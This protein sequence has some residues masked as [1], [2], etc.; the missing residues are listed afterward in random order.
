M[1]ALFISKF[2]YGFR[3]TRAAWDLGVVGMKPQGSRLIVAS[4]ELAGMKVECNVRYGTSFCLWEKQPADRSHWTVL[5]KS[6]CTP[7]L[8]TLE[9]SD[10]QEPSV[11]TV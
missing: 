11:C 3:S 9:G 2:D 1:G 7:L 8:H 10:F 6:C 4:P 5:Q